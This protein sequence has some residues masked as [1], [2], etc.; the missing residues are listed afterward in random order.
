MAT[1]TRVNGSNNNLEKLLNLQ[2][3][4]ESSV[5]KVVDYYSKQDIELGYTPEVKYIGGKCKFN[6]RTLAAVNDDLNFYRNF[7]A[8]IESTLMK[9]L[10]DIKFG[11]KI[12]D[13]ALKELIKAKKVELEAMF[14]S[15]ILSDKT[16]IFLYGSVQDQSKKLDERMAHEVWRLIERKYGVLNDNVLIHKG[17]ATYVQNRFAGRESEWKESETDYFENV[18][19]NVAYLVQEKVENELD[20][21]KAILEVEKRKVIQANFDKRVLPLFY[22]RAAEMIEAGSIKEIDKGILLEYPAY[23]LFRKKPNK[24]NLLYALSQRGYV[25]LVDELLEQDMEKAVEYYKSLLQDGT[26]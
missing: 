11:L 7:V 25:K 21:F 15:S 13:D 6:P 3:K 1:I 17:T 8:L 5:K 19:H 26:V 14:P 4:I 10:F 2:Y 24:N 12:S 22:K 20:P 9:T 16:H 23:E 18:C